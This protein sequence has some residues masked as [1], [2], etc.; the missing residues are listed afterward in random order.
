MVVMASPV[1]TTNSLLAPTPAVAVQCDAAF[2]ILGGTM[3]RDDGQDG[4]QWPHWIDKSV[5]E[6][7][8]LAGAGF[9]W[10]PVSTLCLLD[11]YYAALWYDFARSGGLR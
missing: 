7:L 4:W 8:I 9:A 6:V 2:A 1:D 11:S 3:V 10:V 5:A